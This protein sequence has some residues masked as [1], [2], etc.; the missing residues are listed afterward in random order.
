MLALHG[1]AGH[2]NERWGGHGDAAAD[3][4]RTVPWW[5]MTTCRRD[6]I[7]TVALFTLAWVLLSLPW[8]SGKWTIP[9]DAKAHFQ[10][11]V[12]FLANALHSG[13][14]PFWTPN[15]FG[16][17][18]QI[19]DPQSLIFSPAILLA[20][21]VPHPDF[22]TVDAFV[23]LL[24]AAGGLAFLFFGLD[25]GW[26]PAGAL[27]AGLAFAFGSSAAWRIQHIGQ[28]ESYAQFGVT[29][30]LLA[31]AMQ[32][33]SILYGLLSGLSGG[34]MLVE[35]DQVALLGAYALAGY[36][37]AEIL[38]QSDRWAALRGV[39][40]PLAVGAVAGLAVI[41]VP[42]TLTML[43][44][45][46]TSRSSIGLEE[47]LRGSL[48][49]V[50]LLTGFFSDLF[51][52][53]DPKV[54][55]W[56]PSSA[57]WSPTN[58]NLSQNMSQLY[59]GAL[60]AVALLTLGI[61]RGEGLKADV[62]FYAL[63]LLVFVLYALGGF[64]PFY[65]LAYQVV[66]GVDLF[67]RP[68]DATFMIGA[69]AALLG[70]Y[71]VHKVA[72]GAIVIACPRRLPW[73]LA[74]LATL[75][76]VCLVIG[77]AKQHA[78]DVIKPV[79]IGVACISLAIVCLMLLQRL[80]GRHVLL[81]TSLVAALMVTDLGINNG[82]NESTA[83][84]PAAFD[85]LDPDCKN[86]TI[87]MLKTALKRPPGSPNRDRV[88]LVGMGFEWPNAPMVHGF[89]HVLG[90]NPLRLAVMTNAVGAGDTVA[91]WDQRVFTPLF[92]SYR[93]TLADMLGLRYIVSGVPVEKI[94]KT[95][96][97]G[98]LTLIARTADG[99]VYENR[100]AMPRVMFVGEW[101]LA[102]F[103]EL[104]KTGAWP[105]F[106]PYKTVLLDTAPPVMER[107][108]L[109][110]DTP[111]AYGYV[112]LSRYEN[113]IVE[114]EVVSGSPGFV[115]LNDVWHPWWRATIDGRPAEMM[116]ANVMFRAVQIPAGSHVVRFEF[117]PLAGAVNEIFEA[118]PTKAE[119]LDLVAV[120]K[121][122]KRRPQA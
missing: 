39:W 3:G 9:Y 11:Q 1:Q 85:I 64:T 109:P 63:G 68:A 94:D 19:A 112:E 7:A 120:R 29:L 55:Y 116:R 12:Q 80:Q 33:R 49:P 36:A 71:F 37:V 117:E 20:W 47:A 118:K 98:D 34:F 42:L 72:S 74:L 111:A 87:R 79:A 115:L 23:L 17:S 45:E 69:M 82:P 62:R 38:G 46:Q 26:H 106:D 51:G 65:A 5:R 10:A 88:E 50:S 6:V 92:P 122:R 40:K 48:H 4:G 15:V 91:G 101:Q 113:T 96:K 76:I 97:P 56:G 52:A 59:L 13:Q 2:T 18:P 100:R 93:S 24:L 75:A 25:R 14:S 107:E 99:Y 89:D 35:P 95:I 114:V 32:R 31:R 53:L 104:T 44:V 84:P 22:Q 16:G 86:P 43:F 60:P 54:N 77:V 73:E 66:P 67:R 81:S 119:R 41:T 30:F 27:V 8:L 90:Y 102:D 70:G 61:L 105:R 57:F 103:D 108:E 83:L 121:K 28:I 110:G 21:F 58:L 78:A